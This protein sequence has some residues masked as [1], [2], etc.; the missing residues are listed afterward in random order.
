[1]AEEIMVAPE[2]II[3][4]EFKS[5]LPVLPVKTLALL[6]EGLF[7]YGCPNPCGIRLACLDA[8]E[9]APVF[10][11]NR[12]YFL[13]WYPPDLGDLPGDVGQEQ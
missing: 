8:K 2:I 11:G 12:S 13:N 3:D 4:E 6:E 5:L 10:R 1:M 7:E 9:T